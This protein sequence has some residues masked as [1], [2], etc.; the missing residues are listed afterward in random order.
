[1]NIMKEK[2]RLMIEDYTPQEQKQL[3][4]MVASMDTIFMYEDRDKNRLVLET[5]M[6]KSLKQ[7]FP[8]AK[9]T[10]SSNQYWPYAKIEPVT[11]NAK[12]RNQL[13]ID[14]INFVL[15]H[16]KKQEKLA[17]ILSPGTGKCEPVSTE[18][19]TPD[20]YKLMGDII[21]G[22]RVFGRDGKIYNVLKVFPQGVKEIYQITFSDGRKCKC[23]KEH[24]WTILTGNKLFHKEIT[25]STEDMLHRWKVYD[26]H[27][28]SVKY[29]YRIP[30]LSAP[31]QYGS[32]YFDPNDRI[33]AADDPYTFASICSND[34]KPLPEDFL[35]MNGRN[36]HA[37]LHGAFGHT[38]D[39]I[40]HNK[41][42][43]WQLKQIAWSLGLFVESHEFYD[44][45]KWACQLII[46]KPNKKDAYLEIVDIKRVKDEEAQCIMV[47]SPDHL[48]LT[49]DFIVT[50]NT[51]MACYSAIALR[52]RTLFIAPTSGIK[53]Q[54][55]DTLT[56]MFNV[57]PSRVLLMDNPRQLIN[58][59]ADFVVA[60]Q[61]SL[62]VLDKSYDLEKIL[63]DAK[64]G[65][66]VIDEVQMWFK[67]I[68]TVD[69]NSNIANNWYLTGT[70]GRSG[71]TENKL[72][73]E[74]FGDLAIFREKNKTPTIFNRKPGNVYGM[75][76]Y[77]Y[78]T[79]VWAHSKLTQDQIKSVTNSMRYSEREGKWMR[80]GIS[81]PAYMNL[82][83]PPDG[84]MTPFLKTILDTVRQAENQVKYGKTLVLGN[85]IS[86]AEIV[87]SYLKKMYPKKKIYTYH[88]RHSKQENDEAKANC[89]ILVST[90]SS[91]GT[92]FDLKG[93]GKLVVYAQYRSWI[94][95]SQ[96]FGRLRRRDDGKD[97][98][99]WDIVDADI[100]QLR[101]WANNR[102]DVERRE[103]KKFKVVD[104]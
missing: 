42:L 38:Y 18:L 27:N 87:A 76:P 37:T 16:S 23:G 67:N 9:W 29:L 32:S 41:K 48:Y 31:V 93:L 47:D 51:F 52:L 90:V 89:D 84:S 75:K 100:K 10:D 99:M 73:Q 45:K 33:C 43:V 56:G 15:E 14:F 6:E 34:E 2:T 8:K 13:Q 82:V 63:K 78:C 68:V 35:F 64:F 50:H 7:K 62:Q 12:P 66:K 85:T 36:R 65:I 5:G 98:Y 46:H 20:G 91:A 55:A 80:F 88:S 61:A 53:Q 22:D 79:M 26:N 54:W 96:I 83:I 86:T 39:R 21:P 92:G 97:C 30:V 81:V 95:T 101:V 57:D 72:Y 1:M 71:D 49:K 44:D 69:A 19:P 74:M 3:E 60:S 24:L 94:L 104:A 77:R 40:F 25:I 70:F 103:S 11:H 17:G 59:K 102:A 4:D 58:V 28:G